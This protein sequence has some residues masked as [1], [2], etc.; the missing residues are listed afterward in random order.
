[1]GIISRLALSDIIDA[2]AAN[3]L[4]HLVAVYSDEHGKRLACEVMAHGEADHVSTSARHL[5]VRCLWFDAKG[6]T[7]LHNHP[8]GHAEPS[9]SDIRQTLRLRDLLA[10]L[11]IRLID[12]L[13]VGRDALFSLRSGRVI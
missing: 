13:I 9:S 7:L 12:H 10:P 1:M 8:S 4:E 6:L 2:L 5:V 11:D 3:S